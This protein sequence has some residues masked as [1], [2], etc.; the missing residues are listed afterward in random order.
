MGKRSTRREYLLMDPALLIHGGATWAMVGILI[1]VQ[2]VVYPAMALVP[3]GA[4]VRYERA[5][6]RAMARALA[7]VA[8]LEAAT[9][10]WLIVVPGEVP[11]WM[12]VAGGAILGGLWLV[13]AIVFVPI[14]TTLGSG[15]DPTLQRRLVTMNW[16][17]T[18]GWIVRGLIVAAMFTAVG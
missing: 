11:I 7:A 4:F 18:I 9:A 14:H 13:T 12:P 8:P 16:I 6:Q 15:F 2:I 17:R 5:H 1:M 10:I 3:N